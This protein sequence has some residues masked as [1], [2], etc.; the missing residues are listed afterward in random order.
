MKKGEKVLLNIKPEYAFGESG[1][2]SSGDDGVVPPNASLQMDLGLVSWRI[3]S[4]ITKDKKVLKKILKEGE[5]YERPN[6]G[7]MVLE[8]GRGGGKVTLKHIQNEKVRKSSFI[9]RRKGLIKKVSKFSKNFRVEVCLIVCDGDGDSKPMTWPQDLSTLQSMLTKYEQQKI[10]TTPKKFDMQDYFANKKNMVEA[11]ILNVRKKIVMN[12]YPTWGRPF[13]NLEMEQLR[14]FVDIVDLKIEACNQRINMLKN[15][16]QSDET[17]FM[18]NTGRMQ[19]VAS[20]NVVSPLSSQP[21]DLINPLIDIS[22]MIDFSDLME[23]DEIMAQE[24]DLSSHSHSSQDVMHSIPQIQHEFGKLDDQV[25]K[26]DQEWAT[27]LEDFDDWAVN[28]LN[29]GD[30]WVKQPYMFECQDFCFLSEIEQQ[31]ATLDA[32]YQPRYGF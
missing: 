11:E 29:N 1:K 13:N 32:F 15:M 18:Q 17:N 9:Q 24:N 31:C 3:V 20:E 23:W 16:Q 25:D 5:G 14:S 7:A 6:D 22:E 28:K 26:S 4:D 21:D 30:G 2:P 10:E 19:N 8:M 27:Q 12:K